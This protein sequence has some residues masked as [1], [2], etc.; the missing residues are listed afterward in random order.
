MNQQEYIAQL[1]NENLRLKAQLR[2]YHEGLQNSLETNFVPKDVKLL[3]ELEHFEALGN[4][5]PNGCL[6]RLLIDA[7]ILESADASTKDVWAK[8]LQ[9]LYISPSWE[10]I[11]NISRDDLMMDFTTLWNI[12]HPDDQA[13]FFPLIY[14]SLVEGALFNAE[15]RYCYSDTA[16]R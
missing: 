7:N 1:E 9:L 5:F 16:K 6:F 11:S 3:T 4:N 12:I 15:I 8:H 14:K 10:Q 13:E 2:Q